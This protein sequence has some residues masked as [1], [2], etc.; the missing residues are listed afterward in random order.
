[1]TCV[2]QDVDGGD[3]LRPGDG[4]VQAELCR[5]TKRLRNPTRNVD[6]QARQLKKALNYSGA[7]QEN[8]DA[9]GEV[10]SEKSVIRSRK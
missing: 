3:R 7:R 9:H 1:M 4:G 10:R 2:Q 6:S 5:G 8:L